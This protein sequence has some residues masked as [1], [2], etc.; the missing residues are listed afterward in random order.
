MHVAILI[1]GTKL[2][3]LCDS[4]SQANILNR[5]TYLTVGFPPLYPSQTIFSGIGKDKVQS[6]GFFQ[7]NITI[8][9]NT[10]PA[11]IHVLDDDVFPL[12]VIIGID[13]L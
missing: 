9:D 1:K 6:I 7:D 13:I 11:T 4:G 3:A 10:P 8:Q 5:K 2:T 12:D